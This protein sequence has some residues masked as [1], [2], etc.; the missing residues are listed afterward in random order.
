MKKTPRTLF[1]PKGAG[2]PKGRAKHYI[3]H[4]KREKIPKQTPVHVTIK[5][6]QAYKGL[7]SKIFLNMVKLAIQK[8][9]LKRLAIIHFTVQ[10]DH[11]H[12]FIEAKGNQE[13]TQGM[14]SLICSLAERVR[15]NRGL[16][17]LNQFVKERYHLHVLRTPKE[18][19]N[20]V[21]YILG[22]TIKHSGILTSLC[23]FTFTYKDA[24]DFALDP[25][26]FWLSRFVNY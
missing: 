1:N 22:N 15:R 11:L 18:V 9:R 25:P 10:F 4:L 24:T 26:R 16:K 6:N 13:L 14:R 5:I 21:R 17:K 19:K 7:R 23:P 20:A 8:A 3:P 2:R 12:L